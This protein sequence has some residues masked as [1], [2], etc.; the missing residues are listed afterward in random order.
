MISSDERREISERAS[1]AKDA[2][3]NL[4]DCDGASV[5]GALCDVCCTLGVDIDNS[6]SGWTHEESAVMDRIRELCEPPRPLDG[7]DEVLTCQRE[8]VRNDAEEHEPSNMERLTDD[9]LARCGLMRLPASPDG[10]TVRPG[11]VVVDVDT[12]LSWLVIGVGCGTHPIIVT[13]EGTGIAS[14]E[15]GTMEASEC[16]H[17]HDTA[18]SLAD[19]MDEFAE[20]FAQGRP[21]DLVEDKLHDIAERLRSLGGG[22]R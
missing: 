15:Y 18:E 21:G 5:S 7:T 1:K 14:G 4:G 3:A 17:R 22:V 16:R 13:K 2:L 11:Q 19:E 10:E 12:G 9:E 20:R 8:Q 6:C